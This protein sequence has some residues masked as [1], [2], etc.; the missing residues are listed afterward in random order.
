MYNAKNPK[1]PYLFPEFI[2]IPVIVIN[3]NPRD[4]ECVIC[5]KAGPWNHAV[6]YCCEP[7]HDEIGSM[8][9]KYPGLEVGGATVCNKCFKEFTGEE[10]YEN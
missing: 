4:I 9:S 8:S 1:Q 3:L 2:D 7:T 10:P 6:G 5:G